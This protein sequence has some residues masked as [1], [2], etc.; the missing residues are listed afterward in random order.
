VPKIIKVSG[1]LTKLWQKQFCTV[2]L[3]HGAG[4]ASTVAVFENVHLSAGVGLLTVYCN[5]LLVK[6]LWSQN[7]MTTWFYSRFGRIKYQIFKRL[8]IRSNH[9]IDDLHHDSKNI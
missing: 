5:F 1:N 9:K 2:F 3:R 7:H 6:F 4:S 8:H